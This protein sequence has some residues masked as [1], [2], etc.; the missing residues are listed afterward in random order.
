MTDDASPTPE[1]AAAEHALA[2]QLKARRPVPRATFR[3][4]LARGLAEADPGWGPRPERLWPQALALIA[5]GALLLL[6]GAVL[7]VGGL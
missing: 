2:E 6:V 4:T 1:Q 5:V 7:S 3:E